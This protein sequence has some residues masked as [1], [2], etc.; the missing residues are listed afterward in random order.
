MRHPSFR[1]LREDKAPQEVRQEREA[2]TEQTPKAN[3]NSIAIE[4][5]LLT[6][7][8]KIYWP[9]EK[10]T[11]GDLIE[12]YRQISPVIL[13]YLKDRP[14]SLHRHPNGINGQSFFQKNVLTAV[15]EFVGTTEIKLETE[16]KTIKSVV[17]NN[18]DT[19]LYLANLGCIELNPWSARVGR[20]DYPD[21]AVIDLDPGKIGFDKV[22]EAAQATHK[23]LDK[24]NV[25]SFPKTSG[26]TGLHIFVPL[27]ARYDFDHIKQFVE[28]IV[29]LVYKRLPQTTSLERTPSKRMRKIYL[30]YLQNRIGQTLAAPYCVRP[31]PGATVSA[32]LQWKEIKKGLDPAKFTM[33][34]I[35]KRIDKLGD[36]WQP[37][38]GKGVDLKEALK[39][40]E[41][42]V[43]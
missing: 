21:W 5:V 12:Y 9:K 25:P 40:L 31:W 13:P 39:E 8:G 15:P 4:Q 43:K 7:L 2:S 36:L 20:L 29:T 17:C 22:I 42:I 38:L 6:N 34:N 37:V 16:N 23:I 3:Q 41:K 14:E 10:Y 35:F 11:K 18:Q 26:K 32:P 24:I 33:F 30:D 19:L 28:I 27:A 1:G